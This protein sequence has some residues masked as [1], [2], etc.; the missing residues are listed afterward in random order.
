MN[1]GDELVR[2]IGEFPWVFLCIPA[3]SNGCH[4]PLGPGQKPQW[5]PLIFEIFAVSLQ[6][7]FWL[8]WTC[9]NYYWLNIFWLLVWMPER[10]MSCH[11][12]SGGVLHMCR[13]GTPQCVSGY[14]WSPEN[15]SK[16]VIVLISSFLQDCQ[17]WTAWFLCKGGVLWMWFS[18]HAKGCR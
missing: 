13:G 11:F 12:A 1:L 3:T 9:S 2:R 6:S 4:S 5:H 18:M 10:V 16:R 8:S 17:H 15:V 7:N 14:F